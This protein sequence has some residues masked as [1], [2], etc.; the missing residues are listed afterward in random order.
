VEVVDLARERADMLIVMVA[1]MLV[2]AAVK[3]R[4]GSGT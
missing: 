2:E 3:V 4:V 1:Y